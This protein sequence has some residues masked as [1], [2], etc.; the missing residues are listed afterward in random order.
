MACD[1]GKTRIYYTMQRKG[2]W[3]QIAMDMS[4]NLR[5][6]GDCVQKSHL[7]NVGDR[8]NYSTQMAIR[9]RSDG[10]IAISPSDVK[11]KP[12]CVDDDGPVVRINDSSAI[13]LEYC[14]VHL[15]MVDWHGKVTYQ[16]YKYVL[17]DNG[18]QPII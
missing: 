18:S 7:R 3:P 5:E 1:H 15:V 16:V 12:I 10:H 11:W 6:S 4:K 8:Y 13:V 17:R 2:I 9:I 14:L